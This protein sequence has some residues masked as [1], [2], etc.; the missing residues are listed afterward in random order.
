MKKYTCYDIEPFLA[1]EFIIKGRMDC[2]FTNVQSAANITEESLDWVNPN[3]ENK[4]N[5]IIESK[6]GIILCEKSLEEQLPESVFDTKCLVF[7][8][9]PK[10]SFIR[11]VD[12][13]FRNNITWGIHPTAVIHPEAEIDNMCYIGP[14]SYIGKCKIGKGSKIFGN[15]HIYDN[16][17]I[18][19]NV[20]VH[21]GTV[22]GAEGFGYQRNEKG[23]FELFPHIGGVVIGNNVDIGS[24]T[25][26][27]RGALGNTIIEE[28]AKI[29][30]LV[31]IAHNVVV[32][33]HSAIIANTMIGGSTRIGEYS[34]IAPS[35]SLRDQISVGN[36][37]TVGM[38][39]VVTK[40]VPKGETWTGSPAK[41]LDE[42]L[43]QQKKLK[44]L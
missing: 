21:A 15:C 44:K 8:D 16:T 36:S 26:I 23:E 18:G 13:L 24:N 7:V 9:N 11:I 17:T 25:S 39:A 32:G 27:D 31:H 20:T 14:H 34:W 43:E 28:G 33:K 6:A 4:V 30:N 40:N 3:K 10:L 22:I 12:K 5:Y 41:P 38:G 1:N 35:A 29:D 2:Y 19:E 42:F 37:T